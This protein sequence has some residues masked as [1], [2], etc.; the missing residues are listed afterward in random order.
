MPIDRGFIIG[1]IHDWIDSWLDVLIKDGCFF[2]GR[3]SANNCNGQ[4][5]GN[6][7][8]ENKNKKSNIRI[9]K[10]LCAA[11]VAAA[12]IGGGV[13]GVYQ[14][15]K[16]A[17][18]S[19]YSN[20]ISEIGN[21]RGVHLKST[22][23]EYG[24]TNSTMIS[25]FVIDPSIGA[26]NQPSSAGG[27]LLLTLKTNVESGFLNVD[28]KTTLTLQGDPLAHTIRQIKSGNISFTKDG[29]TLDIVKGYNTLQLPVTIDTSSAAS[30]LSVTNSINASLAGIDITGQ[31][32]IRAHVSTSESNFSITEKG[33]ESATINFKLPSLVAE[34]NGSKIA[35]I[36]D[37]HFLKYLSEK[38][39]D[40]AQ[41]A[42]IKGSKF[43]INFSSLGQ[44]MLRA[45]LNDFTIS[46]DHLTNDK[47]PNMFI[48][49]TMD[50]NSI[51]VPVAPFGIDNVENLSANI[52]FDNVD[53]KTFEQMWHYLTKGNGKHYGST[54]PFEDF[55]ERSP[56]NKSNEPILNGLK[57]DASISG[58]VDG[59]DAN[60]S[61]NVDVDKNYDNIAMK[62]YS[63]L[64]NALVSTITINAPLDLYSKYV[65]KEQRQDQVKNKEILIENN[66]VKTIV[67]YKNGKT[68]MKAI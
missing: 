53:K 34:A 6:K 59:K 16:I 55:S 44:R 62:D 15:Q 67:Q 47:E 27:L 33:D 43:A 1:F 57:F 65:G 17:V 31:G 4:H 51:Y 28:S 64:E 52:S 29:Q 38:D 42:T 58:K 41:T 40:K 66:Q 32:M 68:T 12:I 20:Y 54:N 25:E 50:A 36:K 48:S 3:L 37:L 10:K 56:F 23:A 2:D 7:K 35:E 30:G 18:A 8:V 39:N 61:W 19:N 45:D 46:A 49:T 26:G 24:L 9:N 60:L 5:K 22:N 14:S 13:Y 63:S 11:V 21:V